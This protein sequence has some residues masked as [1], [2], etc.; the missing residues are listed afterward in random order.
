MRKFLVL[1]VMLVA[2]GSLAGPALA[3]KVKIGGTHSADEIRATCASAGGEFHENGNEYGCDKTCGGSICEVNCK[4]GQCTGNCPKCGHRE[5]P[6]FGVPNAVDLTLR[7]R[8]S[9]ED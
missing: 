5:L 8:P 9:N 7:N 6:T 3:G 1:L 4:S 2:S